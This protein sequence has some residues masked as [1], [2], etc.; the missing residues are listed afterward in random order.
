MGGA[1]DDGADK[2]FNRRMVQIYE[3]AKSEAGY[4]ATY[5]LRMLSEHGGLET[6][7]GLVG[8]SQPAEGLPSST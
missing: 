4:N 3:R 8:S 6:A 5:F 2:V 1:V 7:C